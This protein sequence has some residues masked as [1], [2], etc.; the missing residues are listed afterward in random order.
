MFDVVITAND[1]ILPLQPTFFIRN[2]EKSKATAPVAMPIEIACMAFA[3]QGK[4]PGCTPN[5]SQL[6]LSMVLII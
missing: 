3:S 4:D 1:L 5:V 6:M 2:V